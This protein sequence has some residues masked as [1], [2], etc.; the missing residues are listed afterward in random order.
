MLISNSGVLRLIIEKLVGAMLPAFGIDVS[1][2]RE[3][4]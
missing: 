4:Y 3:C 2:V 1:I